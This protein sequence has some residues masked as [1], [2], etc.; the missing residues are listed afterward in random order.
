MSKNLTKQDKIKKL[1]T[2]I[3]SAQSIFALSGIL[4][5]V[6]V[7][8]YFV[9]GNFNFYFSSYITEFAL[10]AA[11]ESVASTVTLT[12]TAAYV[13]LAVYAL[14]FV[15]C[16]ALSLKPKIGFIACL[17]FHLADYTALITGTSLSVFGPFREEIIIDL[18]VHF[19]ILLFIVVGIYSAY[20]LPKVE[21]EKE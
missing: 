14:L 18:I 21:E 11:D 16:C 2:N 19:F 1:Q 20:K 15:V 3:K 17:I 7:V 8:R 10:K 12:S 6:Y 9:T 5:L 13:I 4:A